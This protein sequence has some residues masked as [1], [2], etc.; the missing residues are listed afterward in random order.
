MTDPANDIFLQ[1]SQGS[2]AAIIQVLNERLS[3]CGVRTRAIF[4]NG[5]LQILCEAATSEQLDVAT[6]PERI[7]KILEAIAPRNIRRVNINSRIVREQQLL[8]LEEISRDPDGQ[9]LW[10]KEILLKQPSLVQRLLRD[11]QN[12]RLHQTHN[13]LA[14][15][16]PRKQQAQKQ[17]MR[18]GLIGA[19]T[20]LLVG[21][22]VWAV[23]TQRLTELQQP[24]TSE[25]VASA[26]V[27]PES[28]TTASTQP[29]APSSVAAQPRS[30]AT[31]TTTQTGVAV[32]DPFVQA[33]R[34]AEQAAEA[35]KQAN[36]AAAWLEIAARWRQ[37]SDLMAAVPESD[38]RYALAQDRVVT[39]LRNSEAALQNAQ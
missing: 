9:L 23:M 12:L 38:R 15:V 6:L 34:L 1:A 27:Q 22:G 4:Q 3:D 28:E 19:A 26:P 30:S 18:G 39:Y 17:L 24:S 11:F 5:V 8:W 13:S 35:G 32:K 21:A 7:R 37:A 2:V 33:V 20:V 16:S 31:P 29:V 14:A 36:S 25:P 10:S